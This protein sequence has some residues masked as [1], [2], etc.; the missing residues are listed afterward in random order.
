MLAGLEAIASGA[1]ASRF[2]LVHDAARAG[3]PP[4]V[5]ARV[6]AALEAGAVGCVPVVPVV[7]TIRRVSED[8]STLV[9]RRP[10]RAVQTPQGFDRELLHRAH[11]EV[12]A[13]GLSVT[14]DAAAIEVLGERVSL[15]EGS[16]EAFKVTEPLDLAFAEAVLKGR[17]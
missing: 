12:R 9:D 6:I 5:V 8:G 13:R 1:W 3:V 17:R 2:V 14:D 15:V 11:K 16:P 7:D 10:L 4:E